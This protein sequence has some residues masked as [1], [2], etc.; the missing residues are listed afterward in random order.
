VVADAEV[1]GRSGSLSGRYRKDADQATPSSAA[2]QR[3]T[4]RHD[5]S[6]PPRT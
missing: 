3:L 5:L 4:E 6:L 1:G 2:R